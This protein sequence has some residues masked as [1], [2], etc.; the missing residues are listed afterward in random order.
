MLGIKE[1]PSQDVRVKEGINK[2]RQKEYLIVSRIIVLRYTK[3]GSVLQCYLC[4]LCLKC[5]L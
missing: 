3:A 5:S 2:H 1:R 4:S